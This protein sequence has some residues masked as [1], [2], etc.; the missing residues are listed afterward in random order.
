MGGASCHGEGV[1]L[2]CHG[3]GNGEMPLKEL[4]LSAI[5]FPLHR[6]MDDIP[7]TEGE[8][9]AGLVLSTHAHANI[10]VDWSKAV[11]LSGVKGYV[12]VDDVPGSNTTGI[13]IAILLYMAC[14]VTQCRRL[15]GRRGVC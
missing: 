11:Q 10:T 1:G 5:L 14:H 13:M 4:F 8:L 6:Y 3:E 15:V 2:S 9:Y 12:G 7:P